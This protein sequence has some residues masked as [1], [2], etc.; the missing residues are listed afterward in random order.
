MSLEGALP[1]YL[2]QSAPLSGLVGDRI[3][4]TIAR[5]TAALP[6]L[7]W[8][9][10]G[11]ELTYHM[12]GRSNLRQV[13]VQV[14][15]WARTSVESEAIAEALLVACDAKYQGALVPGL[16]VRQWRLLNDIDVPEAP[17]DGGQMG[18]WHRAVDFEI[19]YR[20]V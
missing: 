14:D 2:M 18:V 17:D 19:T 13:T 20:L 1:Q 8:Q 9:R 4:P 10:L 11:Q 16:D 3:F 7:T 6:Y 12:T 5:Q 15:V